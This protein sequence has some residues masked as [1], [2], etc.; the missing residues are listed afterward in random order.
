MLRA[1]VFGFSGSKNES[2][3]EKAFSRSESMLG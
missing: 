2:S 3:P 1:L